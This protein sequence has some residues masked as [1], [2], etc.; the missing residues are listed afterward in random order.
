M[1][2]SLLGASSLVAT[3]PWSPYHHVDLVRTM[4]DPRSPTLDANAISHCSLFHCIG[5]LVIGILCVYSKTG[6]LDHETTFFLTSAAWFSEETRGDGIKMLI[7]RVGEA[8]PHHRRL[9]PSRRK[10]W[11]ET[12]S[13]PRALDG[14]GF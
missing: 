7:R 12:V 2:R 9:K 14:K 3:R 10:D 6:R 5:T 8:S 13:P 11:S 4:H 1:L